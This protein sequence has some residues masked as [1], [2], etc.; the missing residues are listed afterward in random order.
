[1]V[2]SLARVRWDLRILR[3]YIH[4]SREHAPSSPWPAL[5]IEALTP[6]PQPRQLPLPFAR[7]HKT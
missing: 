2:G 3:P 1:V 6:P 7:L 5:L 4:P